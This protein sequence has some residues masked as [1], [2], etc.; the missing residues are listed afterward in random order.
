MSRELLPQKTESL[1]LAERAINGVF[2]A[3]WIAT[4]AASPEFLWQGLQIL[5]AHVTR[6]EM[7]SALLVG[8]ILAF[9]V[10]PMLTMLQHRRLT[11]HYVGSSPCAAALM[12]LAFAVA[13]VCVHEAVTMAVDKGHVPGPV[14]RHLVDALFQ[15]LEW[16]AIPFAVTAA[17]FAA[18]LK[19]WQ[20]QPL[21][22]LP[23]TAMYLQWRVFEWEIREVVTTFIPCTL[24][25]VS[26]HVCIRR[27]W[28][29]LAF[30][31]CA[32]ITACIALGWFALSCAL[33]LGLWFTQTQAPLI[34]NWHEFWID[35]RFYLGWIIGL[36][37][38]P[39][40]LRASQMHA[41]TKGASRFL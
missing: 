28:D 7:A 3:L 19:R 25:F 40:G 39:C 18:Y 32:K 26:G 31:R 9:F 34:Y 29:I 21:L 17:W 12:A 27:Q 37:V 24:I 36:I 5:L 23:F 16:A 33:Q 14:D 22:L 20:V 6:I 4:C 8:S 10:E 35:F 30:K 1:R 11:P 2:L 38:A 13:G 41:S 15:A